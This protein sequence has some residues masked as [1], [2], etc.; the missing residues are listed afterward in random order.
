MGGCG[1]L[2]LKCLVKIRLNQRVSVSQSQTTTLQNKMP[3]AG[4][5]ECGKQV[6]VGAKTCPHCGIQKPTGN[7][8]QCV[9][10][11]EMASKKA[12]EW[13]HCGEEQPGQAKWKKKIVAFGPVLL[14][15]WA[16][17]RGCNNHF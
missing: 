13:P 5:K 16:L 8:I 9:K 12:R 17:Q 14:I 1:V 2:F 6:I 7:L 3:Q 15:L 11:G 4:C 10:C